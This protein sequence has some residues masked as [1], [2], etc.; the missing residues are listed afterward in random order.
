MRL[1]KSKKKKEQ[2]KQESD[3]SQLP[4]A[5]GVKRH[6]G[7]RKMAHGGEV[8]KDV[9]T[10]GEIIGYPGSGKPKKMA[11]G[12]EVEEM[13]PKSIA[14]AI[15][16]KKKAK[17]EILPEDPFEQLEPEMEELNE[18]AADEVSEGDDTLERQNRI[19]AIRRKRMRG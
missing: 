18:E 11:H 6:M 8:K 2:Q 10:V 12:G 19:A 7:K 17:E 3:G 1:I 9:R 15:R 5:L 14:Q 4:I 13:K 16:S